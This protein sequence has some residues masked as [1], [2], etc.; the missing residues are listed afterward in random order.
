MY[1]VVLPCERVPWTWG[2]FYACCALFRLLDVG[3][4]YSEHQIFVNYHSLS[5]N[6][7]VTC[8]LLGRA[9]T[10]LPLVSIQVPC[11]NPL[12]LTQETGAY[13]DKRRFYITR[14]ASS[15]CSSLLSN[16]INIPIDRTVPVCC[17]LFHA[18][19]NP[20]Q[21]YGFVPKKQ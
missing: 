13:E 10:A 7:P 15:C 5:M 4:G 8:V 3:H 11:L 12:I 20:A 17:A 9:H 2:F 18:F 6:H 14:T 1:H 21:A 19:L 16:S